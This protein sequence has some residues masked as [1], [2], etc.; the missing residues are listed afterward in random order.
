M[1]SVAETVLHLHQ[2]LILNHHL[3]FASLN[4]V[5]FQF[6]C[7]RSGLLF[8]VLQE[9]TYQSVKERAQL[10]SQSWVLSILAQLLL[11]HEIPPW[12]RFW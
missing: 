5:A 4:S 9:D 2:I 12:L 3:G 11:R 8:S 10:N 7:V 1:G 6:R